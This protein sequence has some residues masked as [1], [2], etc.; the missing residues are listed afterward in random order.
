M[1]KYEWNHVMFLQFYGG[2]KADETLIMP[3]EITV[4]WLS[5]FRQG[6][7]SIHGPTQEY[8]RRWLWPFRVEAKE[9][10]SVKAEN[11]VR[12]PAHLDP[13]TVICDPRF[14]KAFN[15]VQ[16]RRSNLY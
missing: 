6:I 2:S 12:Q 8:A 7:G 14:L 15:E 9:C 10:Q 11:Q 1:D 5:A 3:I 13:T 4:N 16:L